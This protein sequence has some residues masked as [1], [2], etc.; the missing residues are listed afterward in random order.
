LATAIT[1]SSLSSSEFRCRCISSDEL[2]LW[3]REVDAGELAL[4]VD[5]CHPAAAIEGTDFKPGPMVSRGLG[6]LLYDK[7]MRIARSD[8]I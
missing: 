5:A 7:G 3:L 8:T 4:I 1:S 2:S 6:Q